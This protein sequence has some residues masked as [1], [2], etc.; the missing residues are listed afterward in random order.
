MEESNL[1]K[2]VKKKSANPS[3]WR[4]DKFSL[5]YLAIGIG[6]YML[7][8]IIFS[9]FQIANVYFYI[10]F[11]IF[12]AI[13]IPMIFGILYGP[14]VGGVS[15][16]FG[17]LFSDLIL[18]QFCWIWWPMGFGLI[19]AIS[20]ITYYG[21]RVGKYENGGNIF[22]ATLFAIGAG[23]PVGVII[24][25]IISILFDQ[26]GIFFSAF[27]ILPLYF[28]GIFNGIAFVPISVRIIEYFNVKQSKSTGDYVPYEKL[29][30]PKG[31]AIRNLGLASILLLGILGFVNIGILFTGFDRPI[32]FG[33][34]GIPIFGPYIALNFQIS[35]GI[36]TFL[37]FSSIAVLSTLVLINYVRNRVR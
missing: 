6:S 25:A 4:L 33:C 21:Y 15:G 13:A 18:Y 24:P 23:V 10:T 35:L 12:P 5:I 32:N 2:S 20:G 3:W 22:K 28:I 16:F 37:C 34:P 11:R 36:L 29:S 30:I 17:K 7:L 8:D 14:I 19:G 1:E 31:N 26:L 27:Y 9:V